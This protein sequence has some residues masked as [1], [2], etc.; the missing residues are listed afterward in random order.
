MP[1]LD[2]G[3]VEVDDAVAGRYGFSHAL[4]AE[5]LVAEQNPTRL[6]QLHAQI[7][8]ALEQLRAGRIEGS[9]EELAHHACEGASAGTARQAFTL[10]ARR[11]RRR[12]RRPGVGRRGRAPPP[13][14]RRAAGRRRRAGRWQ[15]VELL[16]RMGAA[17]RDT[18][19]VL[20]GRDALVDA[21]L[22]AEELGDARLG[23]RRARRRSARP[24]C[25]RRSTGR[26]RT[27]EP[28]P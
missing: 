5:T 7:T 23:R 17:L 8:L 9:L 27:R 22:G 20:A 6:A 10:L 4:V 1:A 13:G 28:W 3:L 24:T 18:G 19:D 15:R 2:A 21:A 25:G 26:C 16:I 14:A 12:A 11:G